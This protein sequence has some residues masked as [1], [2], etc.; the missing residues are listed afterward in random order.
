MAI[1][2][3]WTKQTRNTYYLPLFIA[4]TEKMPGTQCATHWRKRNYVP[5]HWE[6]AR[7]R[8]TLRQRKK[9]S[10]RSANQQIVEPFMCLSRSASL[11]TVVL[12]PKQSVRHFSQSDCLSITSAS[13]TFLAPAHLIWYWIAFVFCKKKKTKHSLI[14]ICWDW[15]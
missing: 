4:W 9:I 10:E 12:L 3:V 6:K 14:L 1:P 8:K 15:L 11:G 2:A 5:R 13:I 7:K